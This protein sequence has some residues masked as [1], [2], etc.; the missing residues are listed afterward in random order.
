MRMAGVNIGRVKTKEL[1]E[2]DVRTTV[3]LEIKDEF[4]PLPEDTK[5]I[6]RQKTLLG[7]T[8]VE[9]SQGSKE[10]DMVDDGGTLP[11]ARVD[12]DRRA[13][14][15]LRRV[16]R[17]RPGG[18]SPSGSRSSAA[19]IKNGRGQDLNDAFGNFAGL[20][21]RRLGPAPGARRAEHRGAPPGQE[22]GRRVQRDLRA[23]GDAAQPDRHL[24][25]D[26]RGDRVARRGARRG[27]P[28]L[29]DVPRR[30]EGDDGAAAGL[31]GEHA[32]AGQRPQGAGRRPR[33]DDPR[34]GRPL[35]RPAGA[36]P[37]PRPADQ[38][39]EDRARRR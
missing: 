38:G 35:A 39:V 20:R 9:L 36:L 15:D 18:R 8:Y 3:E 37:R 23:P 33:P 31:L 12:A 13:R 6:L 16:R 24:E 4:A 17:S 5:A 34:P 29:P 27:L 25:P 21:D 28:H 11:D 19:A 30:V 2:E 1:N 7:E 22:H 26:V 10:A 32:S 14:R